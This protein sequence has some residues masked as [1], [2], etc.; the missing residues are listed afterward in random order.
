MQIQEML[1]K[2]TEIEKRREVSVY[3]S[4]DTELG[5]TFKMYGRSGK[6]NLRMARTIPPNQ[7]T[8]WDIGMLENFLESMAECIE[9]RTSE[10]QECGVGD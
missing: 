4:Y 5:W 2:I 1:E 8:L 6:H 7:I 10:A 3:I 9:L